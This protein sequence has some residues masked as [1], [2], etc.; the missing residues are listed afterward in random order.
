MITIIG[1]IVN[2]F[3]GRGGVL[4]SF[5]EQVNLHFDKELHVHLSFRNDEDNGHNLDV[6]LVIIL[7]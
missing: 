2:I 7:H 1:S 6:D 3:K 4:W 5:N